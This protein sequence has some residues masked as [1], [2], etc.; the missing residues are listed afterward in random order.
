MQTQQN[1]KTRSKFRLREPEM[2]NVVMLNDDTTTMDFV[3][4]VL[5]NIFFKDFNTAKKLMLQ[6]HYEGQATVGTY[7]L[8]IAQSKVEKVKQKAKQ[9][10]FPLEIMIEKQ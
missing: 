10:G 8:D 2:Y 6:I 3:I 5:M 9:N 1:N 4:E 7:T